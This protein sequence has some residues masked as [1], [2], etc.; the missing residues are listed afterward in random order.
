MVERGT[1]IIKPP[2]GRETEI[3]G[4]LNSR[5]SVNF[6]CTSSRFIE[7]LPED[8]FEQLYLHVKE[9]YPIAFNHAMKE[10][11]EKGVCVSKYFGNEG[12]F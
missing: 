4:T 12:L 7:H 1:V 8:I 2:L 9:G 3:L 10:F 11:Y 6:D 5:L